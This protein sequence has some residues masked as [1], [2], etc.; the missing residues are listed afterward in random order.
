VPVDVPV[1]VPAEVTGKR[2][3]YGATFA[4]LSTAALAFSLLQSMIIPA[5]PVLEHDLHSSATGAT[6]LLTA[7]LLS[8]AIA[9]PI[10]GRVGDMVGKEK[11]LLVVLVALGLGTLLS[12]LATTLPIMLAGRAIQGTGG[13]VFPLA[14]GIIRD[15]FPKDKVSTGVGVM[16]AILGIGAGGGIILAGPIVEHLSYHWLFWIPLVMVVVATV[17]T[18]LFVPESPVRS[19]GT[20]NWLGA[21]LMSAW[22]VTGLV[23]V[24]EGPTWGWMNA[25]VLV[26]FVVTLVLIALWVWAELRSDSPVVDMTMM[27]IPAVWTTNLAALLFGFGMFAMFITVPQFVQ[28]PVAQGYGFGASIT[29]SGLFLLPFAVAMLLVAPLT[30]RIAIAI[31]SKPILVAGSIFAASSYGLLVVAHSRPWNIYVASGLLGI[32][33]ALGYASMANLIIEAVPVDQTGVATGM[34]T[35]IR[36]I[37]AALGAGIATSIIVS[38]LMKSGF[39]KE[40]GYTVSFAVSGASLV[41]AALAALRIPNRP[42]SSVV[43]SLS[44]RGLTGEAEVFLGASAHDRA[45]ADTTA[46]STPR[47]P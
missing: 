15:E 2:I 20:V 40:H 14:F 4:V 11:M 8:A 47:D 30:G 45:A 28:T 23:A 46:M 31:G 43:T 19:P 39:P 32:G 36:N 5:I 41:I 17:A 7:Y 37:G 29:Q 10:L 13:A 27:R 1:D 42:H 33:I 25:T 24:S 26:L 34:N 35:N 9:T 3:H 22:L 12:A 21:L 18:F 6:W 38:T 16:S 44:H